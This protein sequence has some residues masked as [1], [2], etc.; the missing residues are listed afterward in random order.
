MSYS[1]NDLKHV[2]NKIKAFNEEENS[3]ADTLDEILGDLSQ[4]GLAK[5]IWSYNINK[6]MTDAEAVIIYSGEK[7]FMD[8]V[9]FQLLPENHKSDDNQTF[10]DAEGK[11]LAT[12]DDLEMC[13]WEPGMGKLMINTGQM[14]IV[15]G[16]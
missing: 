6:M 15:I 1:V 4:Q 7:E 13:M 5:V 9:S 10:H 12:P 14:N 2:V 16:E 8:Q 11:F 3:Y